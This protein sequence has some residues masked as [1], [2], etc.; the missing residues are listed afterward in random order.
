MPKTRVAARKVKPPATEETS[1]NGGSIG[2]ADEEMDLSPAK[3][4]PKLSR[5]TSKTPRGRKPANSPPP[6]PLTP[7]PKPE[8]EKVA[9]ARM[10]NVK[11]SGLLARDEVLRLVEEE[12]EAEGE[13]LLHLSARKLVRPSRMANSDE[14]EGEGEKEVAGRD[15]FTIQSG[16][17]S[18]KTQQRMKQAKTSGEPGTLGAEKEEENRDLEEAEYHTRR[19]VS[20]KG[21]V[22][23]KRAKEQTLQKGRR[24]DGGREK[25][26]GD[27]GSE[28]DEE[29]VVNVTG[30]K[31]GREVERK[32]DGQ[33]DKAQAKSRNGKSRTRNTQWRSD[34][35]QEDSEEEEEDLDEEEMEAVASQLNRGGGG[36]AEQ[37]LED[38]FTAHTRAAGPTSDH[39]LSR[40]ARPRLEQEAIQTALQDAPG[41]FQ[42]DCQ[43][44]FQEYSQLYSYWLLQMSSDYNILLYGLGSKKRLMEDFCKRCLSESC[45]LVVNGY[46]PGLSLKQIL[47]S[48]SSDLLG[49]SGS[50]KSQTEHAQF[51][52]TALEKQRH[53]DDKGSVSSSTEVFLIIHNLDGP[54]LRSERAQTALSILASSKC[55][56]MMASVDHI[57]SSLL[58]DQ[59]RL[60][61]FRWAWH[62][63]TTFET[64]REE[65][66]YENSLLVQQSGS[67]ALS[68]LTH[69]MRSLTPNARGIFELVARY[70]LENRKEGEKSYQGLSFSE[71]YRRCREKFL[72]N[73]DLTLRAQLTEFI[74][75]KLVRLGK[76][77]D[78][79]EYLNVPVDDATLSQFLSE[80]N[81]Q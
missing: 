7:T 41:L 68:S 46:F 22:S 35:D 62:D 12:G 52:V 75:H 23:G 33:R 57:N 4:A 43:R 37:V 72:V 76:G 14:E 34:S 5:R 50:F 59:T 53:P 63:I 29:L 77:S 18:T 30:G 81:D 9:G 16:Q 67:L 49:Y 25:E 73:S 32:R 71:C 56:H 47:T 8:Q 66:S 79:V 54:M 3:T 1:D 19:G 64:Y 48:L 13:S 28:N 42:G 21:K 6:P 74:D 40:L 69:V 65:T 36:V 80:F 20:D 15:I 55:V 70:Q 11:H 58:W 31:G 45:H 17:R 51:I 2:S 44:L 78:G 61:R 39:T 60:S 10:S 27:S 38:Y 26:W 24:K